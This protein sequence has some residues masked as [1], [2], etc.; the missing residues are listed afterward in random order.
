M[1]ARRQE[2]VNATPIRVAN[3]KNHKEAREEA[4]AA[5]QT[6]A[7]KRRVAKRA[8]LGAQIHAAS[9]IARRLRHAKSNLLCSGRLLPRGST[10]T[11]TRP[12]SRR[13]GAPVTRATSRWSSNS[14]GLTDCAPACTPSSTRISPRI[15]APVKG[16][17]PG[18]AELRG[19]LIVAPAAAGEMLMLHDVSFGANASEARL[20]QRVRIR[21]SGM[22]YLLLS[23]C[24]AKTGIV[25]FSGQTIWRNPHGHLPGELYFFL[26]FFG[27]L[28]LGYLLMLAVWGVLCCRYW[29]QLL[30]LQAAIA[31]VIFLAVLEAATWWRCYH[32]FN[33]SGNRGLLPTVL[34]VFIS[35]IRKTV[36]RG[37][38]LAVCLGYGVVRPTLGSVW[39][40]ILLL[41]SIYFVASGALDVVSNVSRLEEFSL[42]M[43]LLFV[44]PVGLLDALSFWWC[45]SAISRTLSQLAARRQVHTRRTLQTTHTTLTHFV[46]CLLRGSRQR[47]NCT[48]A[49]RT[50]SSSSLS[51]PVCGSPPNSS[52]YSPTASTRGGQ[53]SGRL[54][55]DGT[56]SS[57]SASSRS[58]C[59]GA[60]A[61][62]TCSTHIWTSWSPRR[63]EGMG[64]GRGRNVHAM[65][66]PELVDGRRWT[67]PES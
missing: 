12:S 50:S 64:M 30:P 7:L 3:E 13:I 28:T 15:G 10:P 54:R 22:H 20:S 56:C 31:G 59:C 11:R 55:P 49:S 1:N 62:T 52:S 42:P 58:A 8:K 5:V 4:E 34:G 46:L 36:S 38:V 23:S 43:R 26:P 17:I 67:H 41:G 60:R 39:P 65:F 33:E 9:R 44:L 16:H 18:C 45:C 51:S 47:P 37:L 21:S 57:S 27:L 53:C 14:R 63:M 25:R 48:G 2:H 66:E 61:R 35:T 6:A 29:S 24:D 40:R 19:R 32:A